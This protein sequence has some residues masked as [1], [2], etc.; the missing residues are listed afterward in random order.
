MYFLAL[1]LSCAVCQGAR[2]PVIGGVYGST[3]GGL[4]VRIPT[5]ERIVKQDVC[6]TEVCQ[7]AGIMHQFIFFNKSALATSQNAVTA[8]ATFLAFY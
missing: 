4:P 6:T 7:E 5:K 2:A 8:N 1:L 3:I